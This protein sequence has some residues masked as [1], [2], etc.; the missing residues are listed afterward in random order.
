MKRFISVILSVLYFS[1]S[2]SASINLHFCGGDLKTIDVNSEQQTC[3]CGTET[4]HSCCDNETFILKIDLDQSSSIVKSETPKN[5]EVESELF[6]ITNSLE[7]E[8]NE[9][10]TEESLLK[11][12]QKEPI[13]LLNCI[14]TYYG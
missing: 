1:L 5:N 14:F 6:I 9:D 12:P 11:L 13:W 7:N 10:L 8:E 2:T 4:S 3:C